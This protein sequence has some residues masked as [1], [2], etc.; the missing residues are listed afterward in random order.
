MAVAASASSALAYPAVSR[1]YETVSRRDVADVEDLLPRDYEDLLP[2][3]YEDLLLRDYEELVDLV[4][5][6]KN[7]KTSKSA[8][9]A[10]NGQALAKKLPNEIKAEIGKQGLDGSKAAADRAKTLGTTTKDIQRAASWGLQETFDHN[11][12]LRRALDA[13]YAELV[14]LVARTKNKKTSKSAQA[15]SNGQALAKELPNEIKAEI[16]KQGLDGSKAAADRA[17]TLGTTTKD[18]Q[19]AYKH[20]ANGELK[21]GQIPS[22]SWGLQET[23]DHNR[24]L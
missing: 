5:R 12:H 9:A 13:E 18:I 17:K 23:F 15:A 10:S 22:A 21:G 2:R 16:G 20:K 7:K 4:A 14:D 6:T 8:Q 24:H 3:D 11:R 1:T 19:R